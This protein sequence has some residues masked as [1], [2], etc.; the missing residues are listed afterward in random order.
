M[1][2]QPGLIGRAGGVGGGGLREGGLRGGGLRRG[3]ELRGGGLKGGEGG[4]EK[5]EE[6]QE[7]TI[8]ILQLHSNSTSAWKSFDFGHFPAA[9]TC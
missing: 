5:E 6:V 9:G 8:H 7:A 4:D 1:K 3:G 2:Q